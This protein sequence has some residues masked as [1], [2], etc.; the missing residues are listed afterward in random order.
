VRLDSAGKTDVKLSN[1]VHAG[2]PWSEKGEDR[3]ALCEKPRR[4]PTIS[5]RASAEL[6][7]GFSSTGVKRKAFTWITETGREF[8][9]EDIK[10]LVK[11]RTESSN[12]TRF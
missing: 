6:V 1:N 2:Q 11:P 12:M 3:V 7:Q 9:W 8:S 4:I 10:K 5:G